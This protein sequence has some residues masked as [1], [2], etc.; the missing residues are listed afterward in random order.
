MIIQISAGAQWWLYAA[1]A[2]NS[3]EVSDILICRWPDDTEFVRPMMFPWPQYEPHHVAPVPAAQPDD[4]RHPQWCL[5]WAP[6]PGVA[7]PWPHPGR[8]HPLLRASLWPAEVSQQ[9]GVRQQASQPADLWQLE[10]IGHFPGPRLLWG[11][12]QRRTWPSLST[13]PGEMGSRSV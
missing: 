4:P 2:C 11:R 8:G 1:W 12:Q 10:L 3:A 13:L 5:V 6:G 7:A 9:P